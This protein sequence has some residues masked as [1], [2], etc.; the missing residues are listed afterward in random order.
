[1]S[2]TKRLLTGAVSLVL[3]TT[4]TSCGSDSDSGAGSGPG[5]DT[6]RKTASRGLPSAKTLK[7]VEAFIASAG[8]PCTGVT[9]DPNADGAPAYGFISP[10]DEDADDEDK[11]EAAEWSIKEAGFCGDTNSDLGG[12]IIYLPEDMKAYQQRYKDSIEKDENGEWSDLDRTGTA[13]VG[14]D[15]VI[16]TTNLVRENPLLQSGLLILNCYPEL[17][18]P[19]GYRTQDALVDGCVLTDYAPDTSE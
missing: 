4:L 14:A 1:M 16:D 13:L 15:F 6:D 2:L 7:D 10:T 5:S 17:K 9:T 19:S 18:V 12:W 8:L 11:K 3:L